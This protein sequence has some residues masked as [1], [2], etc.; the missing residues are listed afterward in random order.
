MKTKLLI[1]LAVFA[2]LAAPVFAQTQNQN[3]GQAQ[4][5]AAAQRAPATTGA[6]PSVRGPNDV[7]DCTGK[8]LGADPDINVRANILKEGDKSCQGQ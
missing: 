4:K 3:Q 1:A 5:P 2:L 7:Y 6:G 8:Y